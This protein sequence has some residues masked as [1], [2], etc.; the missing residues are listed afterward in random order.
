M[1]GLPKSTEFNKRIPKQKFYDHVCVSVVHNP[2]GQ[3]GKNFSYVN[4]YA[5]FVFPKQIKSMVN[6][7]MKLN[8]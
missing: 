1:I 8:T 3:Q 5:I 6:C 7:M 2:R 4:E